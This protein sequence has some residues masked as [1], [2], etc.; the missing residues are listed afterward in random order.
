MSVEYKGLIDHEEVIDTFSDYDA[1]LF[2]TLSENYGHVI[3]ESL[4]A[5][6]PVIIS[7]QTPWT[8][9]NEK[10]AGWAMAL[11]DEDGYISVM[12]RLAT[13]TNDEWISMSYAARA[14]AD[15]VTDFGGL[16][17]CYLDMFERM[18]GNL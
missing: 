10:G 15:R 12:R 5:G 16:R 11:S 14:Y 4:S 1:F 18:V 17:R 3:A 6:C 2:P 7:D 9:V 13:M 8:P